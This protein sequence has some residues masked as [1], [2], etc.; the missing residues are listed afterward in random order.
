MRE[1]Y[2]RSQPWPSTGQMERAAAVIAH[3][4]QLRIA[5]AKQRGIELLGDPDACE[6]KAATPDHLVSLVVWALRGQK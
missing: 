5:E 2:L 3:D 6:P 1:S 4:Q